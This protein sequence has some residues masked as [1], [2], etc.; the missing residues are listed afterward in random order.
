MLS[1]AV[2]SLLLPTAFHSAFADY[3]VAD[4]KTLQVSRGTSVIL[5]LVYVLYLVFQL[6]SHAYM[7]ASTPQHIIDEESHPGVLADMMNSSSSSDSSSSS[8]SSD[9]DSSTGSQ[10]TTA[11]R[12]KRAFRH[13][14][15][16]K[17]VA[18]SKDTPN[19]PSVLSSPSIEQ[20][21]NYFESQKN[22]APDNEGVVLGNPLSRRGSVL[23]TVMSG[24]EADTDDLANRPIVRDFEAGSS[25]SPTGKREKRKSKHAK[26]HRKH[27]S[28]DLNATDK[29]PV[30]TVPN[31]V[32]NTNR[33]AFVDNV[34]LNEIP[35]RPYRPGLPSLLS[36]NVFNNPQNPPP[37]PGAGP[38][39][40]RIAGPKTLRRTT[41]L[42]DRMNRFPSHTSTHTNRPSPGI[43]H[44]ATDPI[45][46]REEVEE[47]TAPEMSRTV[48]VVMLCISTALVAVCADFMSDAIEPMV[49][50]THISQAFIGLIILPI[51]G[52]AA[53]HVTAVTVAAKN[54][55]DLA[56]GVAVG[57]SIQI[58]IFITPFVVL[59]G[60]AMG[61]EM[62]LYFNIFETVSL[63]VT[64]FVVNFLVLDGR[65]NYLE[66]SL[67]IAAYVIIAM[68]SFFYP[69][70]CEASAIGGRED[71]TC[72][73]NTAARMIRMIKG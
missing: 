8:S 50:N 41:S 23:N 7:Y 68:A 2:M 25:I 64:A 28:K 52:N 9:S 5:L 57:S 34:Q 66:G 35:R 71:V 59:L 67:L 18:S 3:A 55:M 73:A 27:G 32:E 65:S 30:Q 17:S 60:W 48:A 46:I 12:I 69:E 33:V 72:A 20:P 38:T 40:V 62:S 53:E 63:F 45:S 39:N 37:P 56:I 15:R 54:K 14:K 19:A 21:N 16:R 13:R 26:K 49:A 51:V 10:H 43:N 4:Q 61:K 36:T 11:K 6:K 42:P 70:G 22:S 58:A 44:T 24:D 1:L 31:A 47:E 29:V